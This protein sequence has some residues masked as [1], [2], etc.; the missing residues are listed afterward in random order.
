MITKTTSWRENFVQLTAQTFQTLC[1][2]P[3]AQISFLG[4]SAGRQYVSFQSP[5]A[6]FRTMIGGLCN[7]RMQMYSGQGTA[8]NTCRL[9][10]MWKAECY[11]I[12]TPCSHFQQETELASKLERLDCSQWNFNKNRSPLAPDK[13]DDFCLSLKHSQ[14]WRFVYF[15]TCFIYFFFF[16]FSSY[17][18]NLLLSVIPRI[19]GIPGTPS[20]QIPVPNFRIP[21]SPSPRFGRAIYSLGE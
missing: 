1:Y 4:D 14:G 10:K 5:T 9:T 17:F 6:T 8:G 12:I 7:L 2:V 16:I 20:F 11:I 21:C 18:S 15:A 3:S 13:N 19:P